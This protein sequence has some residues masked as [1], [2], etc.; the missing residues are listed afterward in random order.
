M[1][2]SQELREE[3][4]SLREQT[5]SLQTFSSALSSGIDQSAVAA[6]SD[7]QIR[8]GTERERAHIA[9]QTCVARWA[10]V[11]REIDSRLAAL[12]HF[13]Q[14]YIRFEVLDSTRT[15]LVLEQ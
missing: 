1:L 9:M 13:R 6:G 11:T 4:D 7:I 14:T 5:A 3:L 15:R 12:E 10:N 8:T 2:Y